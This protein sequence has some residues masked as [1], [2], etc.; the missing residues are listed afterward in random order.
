MLWTAISLTRLTLDCTPQAPES[1][2]AVVEKR[3][4]AAANA[5]AQAA[6]VRSGQ[7]LAAALALMPTLAWAERSPARETA[8]LAG[9]GL[10]AHEFSSSIALGPAYGLVLETGGSVRLF[11][12][13]PALLA[14]M[15]TDLA[16][17]GFSAILASAPTPTGARMLAK[18]GFAVHPATLAALRAALPGLPVTCLD[19]AAGFTSTFETLGL[20]T[21]A[22]VLALPRDGLARRFGAHIGDELDRATGHKPDP[23]RPLVTPV[24]FRS[25]IVLPVPTESAE[26]LQFA[27]ARA[28]HQ[29]ESFLRA[30]KQAVDRI[31]LTLH[32]ERGKRQADTTVRQEQPLT[33]NFFEPSASSARF[34]LILRERLNHTAL[35]QPVERITVCAPTPVTAGESTRALLPEPARADHGL[36]PLLERLHARLG[37]GALT[38]VAAHAEH[39]PGQ[40]GSLP[41]L[42]AQTLRPT[43]T[44][45]RH[46][47]ADPRTKTAA[48][49]MSAAWGPRPVW[50][51]EPPARLA[52]I[53]GKPHHEGPLTLMAGPERIE[54][55]WW[56]GKAITRDY[57]I[58]QTRAHAL[59][60]VFR[61]R[62][63][64]PGWFLQGYFG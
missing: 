35:T 49:D 12:G 18:S 13:L 41:P 24:T 53:D 19:S 34:M 51:V 39:R 22:D 16:A 10:W 26:A 30:G 29:L 52:E 28:F 62:S 15:S 8:A 58:A 60:W 64:P 14:R 37:E 56:D 55:G 2:F 32:H 36:Q 50:L 25:V 9:L 48:A 20:R 40:A 42:D 47:G 21:V 27:C 5:C 1:A 43:R 57:F 23:I 46:A 4:I 6:G 61:E 59:V 7:N 44:I 17:Q 33:L 45:G 11:G 63:L 54:S 38:G 3:R 31:D